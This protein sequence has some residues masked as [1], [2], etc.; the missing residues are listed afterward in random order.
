MVEDSKT[1][2]V[3][4]EK[5]GY[6]S[7]QTTVLL[8]HKKGN[9]TVTAALKKDNSVKL[10]TVKVEASDGSPIGEASVTAE[11]KTLYDFYKGSTDESG[12]TILN[13]ET[14]GTFKVKVTHPKFESQERS[15]TIEK[16][17]DEKS[18]DPMTFVLKRLTGKLR[19]LIVTVVDDK[20][21]NPIAGIVV[22]VKGRFGFTGNDGKVNFG[23]VLNMGESGVITIPESPKYEKQGKEYIGGGENWR[24]A[25]PLIDEVI[26]GI[27][28]KGT[29]EI[30]YWVQ[31]VDDD[32]NP[33]SGVAVSA[34]ASGQIVYLTGLTDA[35]GIAKMLL[36]IK[37]G[38]VITLKV[39]KEKFKSQE[40]NVAVKIGN[41][42]NENSPEKFILL[43]GKTGRFEFVIEVFDHDT[44]KPL[45]GAAV[46]LKNGETELDRQTTKSQGEVSLFAD[47]SILSSGKL[48]IVA[49][50]D[51]YQKRSVDVPA[52]LADAKTEKR[53]L[54]VY[55]DPKN[56]KPGF[57]PLTVQVFDDKNNPIEDAAVNVYLQG[58]IIHS[59]A[60]NGL[61]NLNMR[62]KV[63]D[64][65]ML[66]LEVSMEKYESQKRQVRVRITNKE[67]PATLTEKFTLKKPS[68]KF[69]FIV[70]VLDGANNEPIPN[71]S[72]VV[73][74]YSG[75][76]ISSKVRTDAQGK[77]TLFVEE[78]DLKSSQL[79]LVASAD[80]YEVKWSDIPEQLQTN[81]RLFTVYLK[82]KKISYT[83]KKYGP[84]T[85]T[86]DGWKSTGLSIDKGG[87]LRVEASGTIIGTED[88]KSFEMK[89][90]GTGA[91]KW[92]VLKVKIGEKMM[93]VGS[94]RG[95]TSEEG[96]MLELGVP[97]VARFFEG[98]A[99]DK[100]GSW[101]VYVYSKDA[102]FKAE[103]E[104]KTNST[105]IGATAQIGSNTP[106]TSKN[107]EDA[108]KSLEFLKILQGGG[109]VTNRSIDE[110]VAQVRSI[111]SKYDIN[112][113]KR[114]YDFEEGLKTI[115]YYQ[116][117]FGNVMPK[118]K[119]EYDSFLNSMVSELQIII[120]K[121]QF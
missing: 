107:L 53:R 52:E 83:E 97:R 13:M 22:D 55:L 90:D 29:T 81:E 1:V 43:K 75:Q 19:D 117:S 31:V 112:N 93:D 86:L 85:V 69:Q 58:E 103:A 82:K 121:G 106:S 27:T 105:S 89:P 7:F 6:K 100:T 45:P 92:F 78:K 61:G 46:V 68:V 2:P 120:E 4:I 76:E 35:N 88:G 16:Y 44:N 14:G 50:A 47:E 32:N 5:R 8:N 17:N 28:K 99:K 10:L 91:W 101:T 12:I 15:V 116:T 64:G 33:I 24:Y 63:K 70:E 41:R 30:P 73:K 113:V 36:N 9:A 98:D 49:V 96:G 59:E 62:I 40:R 119:S 42:S 54:Q 104:P 80:D 94:N 111:V 66:T 84:Y 108:K 18:P 79:R 39:H 60:T 115:S 20:T 109:F 74:K 48:K 67:N 3:T 11:G 26:V 23:K 34:Y 71:A 77:A 21:Y 87:S 56:K 118:T 57:L 65:E 72:T 51:D 95:T 114:Y 110:I 38:A 37:D 25:P 102:S